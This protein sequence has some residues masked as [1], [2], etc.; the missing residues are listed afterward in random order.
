MTVKL[1]SYE[2][3]CN[4]HRKHKRLKR[5]QVQFLCFHQQILQSLYQGFKEKSCVLLFLRVK[6]DMAAL[7][8]AH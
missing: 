7:I 3:M 4:I 2:R 8:K 1:A 5:C 6:G